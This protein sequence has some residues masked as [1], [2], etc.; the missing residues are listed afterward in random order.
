MHPGEDD[1]EQALVRYL[2]FFLI[3]VW[4][5]SGIIDWLWHKQ[6]DIEHTSSTEES[7]IPRLM[8]AEAGLP[9]RMALLL[10]INSG[11]ILAMFG[12]LAL[13]GATAVWDVHCAGGIREVTEREQHTHSFLEVLPFA[14]VAM[15][16][17]LHWWQSQAL[18]GAGL[19]VQTSGSG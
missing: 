19:A 14:A 12:G 17:C 16:S 5:A 3:P 18:F 11:V 7:V 15:A 9:L 2:L 13:H 1:P 4:N 6:T 8:F 10:E